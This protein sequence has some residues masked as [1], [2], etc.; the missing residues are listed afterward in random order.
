MKFIS[1]LKKDIYETKKINQKASLFITN[2]NIRRHNLPKQATEKDLP[3]N[4][5][6]GTIYL[7]KNNNIID[8]YS[9]IDPMHSPF[10]ELSYNKTQWIS[11]FSVIN[12]EDGDPE[13]IEYLLEGIKKIYYI[14]DMLYLVLQFVKSGFLLY[15]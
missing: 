13:N 11:K 10:I 2:K 3:I 12:K 8:V 15:F 1:K 9:W 14:E 5:F 4:A 7:I 6:L